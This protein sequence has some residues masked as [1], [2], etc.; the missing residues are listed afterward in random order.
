MLLVITPYRACGP[1]VRSDKTAVWS[2]SVLRLCTT[3][4]CSLSPTNPVITSVASRNPLNVIHAPA[5]GSD[6]HGAALP[7]S[8]A[9][10]VVWRSFSVFLCGSVHLPGQQVRGVPDS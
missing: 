5:G 4:S 7:T 10:W 1:A 2:T 6:C 3:L 8:P 9:C